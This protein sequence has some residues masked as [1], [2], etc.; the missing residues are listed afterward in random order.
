MELIDIIKNYISSNPLVSAASIIIIAW[1]VAVFVNKVVL[2][3]FLR[4]T[5]KTKTTI[6]EELVQIASK[7]ISTTILLIGFELALKH[8]SL[9]ADIVSITRGIIMSVIIMIW[10]VAGM[11]MG[12]TVLGAMAK[13]AG[14]EKLVQSRTLPLFEM[15]AKFI[16]ISGALYGFL[17]TWNVDVTVWLASAGIVGIAVGF[18]AKDSLANFFSGI[19]IIAD[20]PYKIGDFIILS[21]G[22]RGQVTEIGIRSTRILNRDDMEIIIPN[23]AIGA[24]KIINETAGPYTKRRIKVKVGVSYNSDIDKLRELLLLIAGECPLVVEDPEPRVRFREFGE[25]SLDFELLCWINDPAD[26]GKAIDWLNTRIFKKFKEE[27]IV[28]P[29][30]QRDIYMKTIT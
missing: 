13:K 19:F 28:I 1:L 5:L 23:A 8:T 27:A 12:K 9:S 30:P 25:S 15:A 26:K 20:A 16:I 2:R 11:K 7:P 10:A 4:L 24:A 6:D 14:K 29:F 18:A 3:V 17:L 22:E 21:T